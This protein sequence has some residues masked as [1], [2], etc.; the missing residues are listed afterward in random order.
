MRNQYPLFVIRLENFDCE[1]LKGVKTKDTRDSVQRVYIVYGLAKTLERILAR[2]GNNSESEF[3]ALDSRHW[4][5]PRENVWLA[6]PMAKSIQLK[7]TYVYTHVYTTTCAISYRE[8]PSVVILHILCDR[9]TNADTHIYIYLVTLNK[10]IQRGLLRFPTSQDRK[11]RCPFALLHMYGRDSKVSFF[12]I[13][14]LHNRENRD[15]ATRREERFRSMGSIRVKLSRR[16]NTLCT[17]ERTTIFS[18][19]FC[20]TSSTKQSHKKNRKYKR[21]WLYS[22]I[23]ILTFRKISVYVRNKMKIQ[24]LI[25]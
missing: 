24:P 22:F 8:F 1:K 12:L 5:E 4:R 15:T 3:G 11:K 2:G 19:C 20:V 6:C 25:N 13:P 14:W 18:T 10:C 9:Y 21:T 16:L 7:Y 23:F 17:Y